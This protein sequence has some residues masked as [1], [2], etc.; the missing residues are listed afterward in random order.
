MSDGK[1]RLVEVSGFSGILDTFDEIDSL[2]TASNPLKEKAESMFPDNNI[3]KSNIYKG[4]VKAFSWNFKVENARLIKR[5]VAACI[6]ELQSIWDLTNK[7]GLLT[8]L[9]NWKFGVVEGAIKR[10]FTQIK[11]R[12]GEIK[13]KSKNEDHVDKMF[14]TIQS[15]LSEL[16]SIEPDLFPN[17][18][19]NVV[20]E[21]KKL[22]EKERRQF[23]EAYYYPDLIVNVDAEL[24]NKTFQMLVTD[25]ELH[26]VPSNC[27]TFFETMSE[28][29][30]LS[31]LRLLIP[32]LLPAEKRDLISGLGVN[33]FPQVNSP[34]K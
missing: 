20:A 17:A 13:I 1:R 11:V 32:M 22:G 4:V 30:R 9:R 12:K 29:D 19:T 10:F 18:Q 14:D 21:F 16:A 3:E 34:L 2:I 24:K 6:T 25:D 31:F 8:P 33:P 15:Y 27:I 28:K 5:R 23:L 26:I 7:K